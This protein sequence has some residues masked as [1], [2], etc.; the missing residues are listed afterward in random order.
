MS[1]A[2]HNPGIHLNGHHPPNHGIYLQITFLA[3]LANY[4]FFGSDMTNFDIVA[5]FSFL[6]KCFEN[7]IYAPQIS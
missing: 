3:F 7:T 1:Y 5:T 4:P 6:K 2:E